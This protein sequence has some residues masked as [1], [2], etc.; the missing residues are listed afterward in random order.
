ME[1]WGVSQR[2]RA[3]ESRR[4]RRWARGNR[5]SKRDEKNGSKKTDMGKGS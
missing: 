5:R 1:E 3:W 4:I 2:E